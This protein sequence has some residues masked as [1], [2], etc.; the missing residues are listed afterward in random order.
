MGELVV[1]AARLRHQG[2]TAHLEVQAAALLDRLGAPPV[3]SAAWHWAGAQAAILAEDP[4]ALEPHAAALVAAGRSSPVAAVWAR[5]GRTWL[6]ALRNEAPTVEVVAAAEAL[7][8]AGWSCD[9]SRLAGHAAARAVHAT[10]RG[11]LLQCARSLAG[12]GDAEPAPGPADEGGPATTGLLSSR[13]RE[14]A[15]LVVAG[16]T[17]R[18]IGSR[19]FISAKTVE[20][21]VAR[22][23]QRVSAADR[24]ELLARLRAELGTAG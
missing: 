4:A 23:R 15:E 14:V 17:Y 10:D 9:G 1:A 13:E 19:L 20:H 16:V 6:R 22:M 24:A 5:A 12:P 3:W 2:Q 11:V 7:S 18:E 21:H 8:R